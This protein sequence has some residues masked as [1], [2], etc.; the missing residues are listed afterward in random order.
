MPLVLLQSTEDMLVNPANVDPFLRGRSSVHHFWSHEFRSGRGGGGATGSSATDGANPDGK[1]DGPLNDRSN[2]GVSG[3]VYGRK[4]LTDLLRALSRPRGA[5]VAW[6]RAGHEVRQEAKRAVLDLLDALAKPTPEY[7]RVKTADVLEGTDGKGT[8]GL[9]PLG[10]FVARVNSRNSEISGSGGGTTLRCGARGDRLGGQSALEVEGDS[11]MLTEDNDDSRRHYDDGGDVALTSITVQSQ[12]NRRDSTT[13][14]RQHE[15]MT[16]VKVIRPKATTTA[17]ATT[18]SPSLKSPFPRDISIPALPSRFAAAHRIPKTSPLKRIPLAPTP[19]SAALATAASITCKARHRNN[20]TR[21]RTNPDGGEAMEQASVARGTTEATPEAFGLAGPTTVWGNDSPIAK[22][23]SRN[24]AADHDDLQREGVNVTYS[25]PHFPTA[26]LPYDTPA[27]QSPSPGGRRMPGSST[28]AT[29]LC[30]DSEEEHIMD[31]PP[32]SSLALVHPSLITSPSSMS[33]VGEI[34]NKSFDLL[35]GA[36]P[37][38]LDLLTSDPLQR[39]RRL[40][41]TQNRGGATSSGTACQGDAVGT[42]HRDGASPPSTAAATSET[43]VTSAASG[44]VLPTNDLLVAEACLEGRLCEV[45]RRAADRRRA[46]EAATE[47]CIAGIQEQ[48]EVRRK[49]YKEEDQA[50]ID[51]LEKQLADARLVRA[52]VDLQ[53]AIDGANL[54]Y[55]IVRDGVVSPAAS[56]ARPDGG[57]VGGCSVG[58]GEGVGGLGVPIRVMPPLEYSPMNE[59][60]EELV[61]AGDAYSLMADAARDQEEMAKRRQ[62]AGGGNGAVG[63][64]EQFQRDQAAAAFAIAAGRLAAKKAYCARSKSELER[65]KEEAALRV[66]PRVRG[67]IGRQR[68]AKFRRKRDERRRYTAAAERIQ[69]A[70]RGRLGR[71]HARRAREAAMTAMLLGGSASKLQRVGRGMLGRRRAAARRRQVSALTLE[72]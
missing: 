4:G 53:R 56:G 41:V 43:V 49:I 2:T 29:S 35:G 57:L 19:S 69:T 71:M 46:E 8:L 36:V 51:D 44:G 40:W 59:L 38:S 21:R 11:G 52:P 32:P 42:L 54:D 39:S 45:R 60:P 70:A 16:T 66:Q 72:R 31:G 7:T 25:T 3:S 20:T 34:S 13:E 22:E 15:S 63:N 58:G 18:T 30:S 68:A 27:A 33:A 6:V 14:N 5:F 62:A 28:A 24:N 23:N 37:P 65:A 55:L 47:Q 48:Q 17:T 10:E 64:L 61:R 1:T 26:A 50:M 9:Y 67:V 12:Q